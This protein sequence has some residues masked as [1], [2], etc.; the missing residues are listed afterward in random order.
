M[1]AGDWRIG[2][3]RK[4]GEGLAHEST[5]ADDETHP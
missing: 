4:A 2:L 5:S 3:K 1:A